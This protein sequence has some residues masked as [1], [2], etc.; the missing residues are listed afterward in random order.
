MSLTAIPPNPP[1]SGG[2]IQ[3][4][5][6]QSIDE[7]K[8]I[9][10]FIIDAG[11]APSSFDKDIKKIT[12]AILKGL[13]VGLPPLTAVST[14]A[15]IN[16]RAAIWGD[17]AIALVQS[18]HLIERMLITEIG[19]EGGP[20]NDAY[21]FHAQI[22]RRGQDSPYEGKFTVADA[23]RAK[24]WGNPSK[25]PWAE[26]PQRMLKIR[27]TTYALRD[28]FA[29]ALMGLSIVEEVR[30]IPQAA[31]PPDS[32]FLDDDPITVEMTEIEPSKDESS[33]PTS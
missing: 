14:I 1:K 21:G 26:Y 5:I 23:K 20:F 6:P 24:L 15:V 17:G 11:L 16:G 19:I 3:A 31:T 10:G 30:D 2:H 9:A 28:G 7:L 18:K 12:I 27:A 25:R 8:W 4:F 33:A 32:S 29:D 13:E 22:W